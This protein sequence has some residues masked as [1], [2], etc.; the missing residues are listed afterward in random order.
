MMIHSLDEMRLRDTVLY[1]MNY[2]VLCICQI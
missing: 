1:L 2:A